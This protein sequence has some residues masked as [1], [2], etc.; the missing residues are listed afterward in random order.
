MLFKKQNLQCCKNC[1]AHL[2]K[3]VGP[4]PSKS[5]FLSIKNPFLFPWGLLM[6]AAHAVL[7]TWWVTRENYLLKRKHICF[8]LKHFPVPG[9][10]RCVCQFHQMMLLLSYWRGRVKDFA[11]FAACKLWTKDP[12]STWQFNILVFEIIGKDFYNSANNRLIL[13]CKLIVLTLSTGN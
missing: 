3:Y 6:C 13:I 5:E 10:L 2:K 12:S 1:W 7:E 9:W 4:N 11:S 8:L